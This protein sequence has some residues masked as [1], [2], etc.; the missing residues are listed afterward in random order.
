MNIISYLINKKFTYNAGKMFENITNLRK[1]IT[2]FGDFTVQIHGVYIIDNINS[3]IVMYL[4][5]WLIHKL[6]FRIKICQNDIK[7]YKKVLMI[8]IDLK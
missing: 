7:E 2:N 8:A 3:I 1:N 4:K 5:L 6:I